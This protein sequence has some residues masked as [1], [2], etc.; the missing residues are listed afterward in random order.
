MSKFI[1]IDGKVIR[2]SSIISIGE[3][4]TLE[5]G[6]KYYFEIITLKGGYAIFRK[7]NYKIEKTRKNIVD[8]LTDDQQRDIYCVD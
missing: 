2:I 4:D 3:I 8:L 6:D 7:N 5:A 1:A